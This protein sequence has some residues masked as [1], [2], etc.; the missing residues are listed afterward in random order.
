[1]SLMGLSTLVKGV[2]LRL[3][4][5][6]FSLCHRPIATRVLDRLDKDGPFGIGLPRAVP[7]VCGRR[8][9]IDAQSS[10][11][12]SFRCQRGQQE[13][14]DDDDDEQ[15]RRNRHHAPYNTRPILPL[16]RTTLP[17]GIRTRIPTLLL[18]QTPAT[19]FLT[20]QDFPVSR[21]VRTQSGTVRHWGMVEVTNDAASLA[22][23]TSAAPF[24]GG[25]RVGRRG[26]RYDGD[27]A[28][29]SAITIC[30]RTLGKTC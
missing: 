27:C 28:T 25:G 11:A 2:S 3:L 20:T 21:P 7:G 22:S 29:T 23:Q 1:M 19:P 16:V 13:A 14:T 12:W 4:L 15:T 17:A 9:Q 6:A 24:R 18:L 30:P 26:R 8:R 5:S 10:P